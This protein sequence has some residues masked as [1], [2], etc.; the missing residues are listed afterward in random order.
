MSRS[1][2]RQPPLTRKM[3]TAMAL[4]WVA[5][6]IDP[7][8]ESMKWLQLACAITAGYSAFDIM[9][10]F[11]DIAYNRLLRRRAANPSTNY[12]TA[13]WA[14]HKDLKKLGIFKTDGFF[15]S[16]NAETGKPMFSDVIHG[17]VLGSTGSGKT[18][19][20]VIPNLLH[21]KDSMVIAD[22][23][24]E[25]A[26][27]TKHARE[28]YHKQKTY[29]INPAR[30]Y[31][32]EL[33]EPAC[34]NPLDVVSDS[35]ESGRYQDVI[36]DAKSIA[37][38][39]L[40]EPKQAG[41]NGFFRK[42]SRKILVF[43]IVCLVVIDESRATLSKVLEI[44]QDD[45]L[46]KNTLCVASCS[47]ALSG[48]LA[49]MAK[50]LLPKIEAQDTRQWESF[51]EG[52]LQVLDEYSQS[53]WLAESTSKSDFSFADLKKE[54]ISVYILADST[55]MDIYDKWLGLVISCA[56]KQLTRCRK[57]NPEVV[58]ML[59]EV[60]N[61][62]VHGLISRMTELRGFGCK[63]M[64]IL[65]SIEDFIKTYSKEDLDIALDQC[66]F[67]LYSGIQ[68]YKTAELISKT[69]GST[70]IVTEQY[71]LGHDRHDNVTNST[72][73]NRRP[74]L[75]PDEIMRFPNAL[76]LLRNQPP[77]YGIKC[78][79]HEVDPWFKWARPNP[80]HGNKRFKG[81]IKLYLKY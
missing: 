75:T 68:S 57:K 63:I 27:M 41:E 59:D 70:T 55:R 54:G 39:L 5:Y 45:L 26:V 2:K 24:P 17:F 6:K 14:T 69:L 32:D 79:Y 7:S 30:L 64:L 19:D 52:A 9:R 23:K 31:I 60:S 34:F 76:I 81:K 29:C 47:D 4:G 43:L 28:K 61:F 36:S 74:L 73:E 18:R 58:F 8:T 1:N 67:Q 66:D 11:P 56:V 35:W 50:D 48:D 10:D 12:G 49:R 38:Q 42:G 44:L 16:L 80:M 33:G 20:W 3:I 37:L 21:I 71:Q 78:G 62:R 53:G 22:L 77:I 51:R 15:L 72:G 46:M 13:R 25:L 65:Q 40:E